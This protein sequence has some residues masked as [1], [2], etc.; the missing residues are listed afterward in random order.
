MSA[1]AP[2]EEHPEAAAAAIGAEDQAAA[3]RV[4]EDQDISTDPDIISTV[5]SPEEDSPGAGLVLIKQMSLI[6]SSF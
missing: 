5:D 6:M 2:E 1:V 4:T 3:P